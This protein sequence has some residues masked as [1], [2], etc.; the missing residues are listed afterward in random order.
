MIIFSTALVAITLYCLL[1]IIFQ[2]KPY[3]SVAVVYLSIPF[4]NILEL[5]FMG[6]MG[7][8]ILDISLI[9]IYGILAANTFA[10]K[11]ASFKFNKYE[12]YNYLLW[13]AFLLCGVVS[14]LQAPTKS[15]HE[16][17][18][19]V[20]SFMAFFL[21]VLVIKDFKQLRQIIYIMLFG[22][23]FAMI[24]VIIQPYLPFNLSQITNVGR[25]VGDYQLPFARRSGLFTVYGYLG[26]YICFAYAISC[27][28]TVNKTALHY[29]KLL[30]IFCVSVI[31][32]GI[33]VTQSRSTW[34]AALIVWSV[35]IIFIIKIQFQMSK[36]NQIIMSILFVGFSMSMVVK[37]DDIILLL[38]KN[39]DILINMKRASAEYRFYQIREGF[40]LWKESPILGGGAAA[41]A[42]SG[43]SHMT[44]H[45]MWI[46][47]LIQNGIVG[48]T[49]AVG[50]FAIS[51]WRNYKIISNKKNHKMIQYISIAFFAGISGIIMEA[52]CV[53]GLAHQSTW[54]TLGLANG[55][56]DLVWFHNRAYG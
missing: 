5:P 40:D 9:S 14:F 52:S 39:W 37:F 17:F 24:V 29:S 56:S 4:D 41:W 53:S 2:R 28:S 45:N 44:L 34:L 20:E 51:L 47:I 55:F 22:A 23:V 32:A 19:R 13:S 18:T 16:L 42:D 7:I 3:I 50:L 8:S 27:I 15:T 30:T 31:T 46:N 26:S 21:P 49:S 36:V 6:N 1:L 11:T 10:F 48:L 33:I 54:L 12:K 43:V 38:N 25:T 35:T